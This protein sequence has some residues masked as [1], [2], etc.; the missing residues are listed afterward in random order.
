MHTDYK[1]ILQM[2]VMTNLNF[3]LVEMM[4]ISEFGILIKVTQKFLKKMRILMMWNKYSLAQ[5]IHSYIQF[6]T[7]EKL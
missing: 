6:S 2:L 3:F 7:T 1:L 5:M 4:N